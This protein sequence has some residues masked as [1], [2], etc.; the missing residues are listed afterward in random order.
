MLIKRSTGSGYSIKAK[1]L[2]HVCNT[3]EP[4]ARL[5]YES[6][7]RLLTTNN[8]CLSIFIVKPVDLGELTCNNTDW[9]LEKRHA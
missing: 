6:I 4:T 1:L 5:I 3:T 2:K 7:Y 9:L 8:F